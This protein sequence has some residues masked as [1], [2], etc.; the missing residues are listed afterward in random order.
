MWLVFRMTL[1]FAL[2]WE[3]KKNVNAHYWLINVHKVHAHAL[4]VTAA[5][6]H[7]GLMRFRCAS[8]HMCKYRDETGRRSW[9]ATDAP[10][11]RQVVDRGKTVELCV[12]LKTF[13]ARR[14]NQVLLSLRSGPTWADPPLYH[15]EGHQRVNMAAYKD[16]TDMWKSLLTF[17]F[18]FL[19]T[20]MKSVC[21]DLQM[22]SSIREQNACMQDCFWPING[23]LYFHI[24][25]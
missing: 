10:L 25:F 5:S 7:L 14:F 17:V 15:E 16:A 21:T 3:T 4:K 19:P 18:Q 20:D 23:L 9:S 2:C 1:T 11:S 13:G 6:F 8:C 22:A 24:T 12:C